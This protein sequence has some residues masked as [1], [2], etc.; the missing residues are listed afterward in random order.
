MPEK[1]GRSL[2]GQQPGL[3][4]SGRP[5]VRT[6]SPKQDQRGHI[7]GP[8]CWHRRSITGKVASAR[9]KMNR[10]C[11]GVLNSTSAEITCPSALAAQKLCYEAPVSADI[12][13]TVTMM[14]KTMVKWVIWPIQRAWV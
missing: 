1:G 10:P 11:A 12:S 9:C 5:A 13:T 4:S 2:Q 14:I 8:A 3:E 6:N 7:T